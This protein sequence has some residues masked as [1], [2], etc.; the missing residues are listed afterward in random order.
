MP[1]LRIQIAPLRQF[2]DLTVELRI[3]LAEKAPEHLKV[4][5]KRP[6]ALF[7]EIFFFHKLAKVVVDRQMVFLYFRRGI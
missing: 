1:G 5:G 4:V 3:A 7:R 2:V 6:H